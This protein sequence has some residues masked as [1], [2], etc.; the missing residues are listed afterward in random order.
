MS[1][2]SLLQDHLPLFLKILLRDPSE[3]GELSQHLPDMLSV[4]F[5]VA[6]AQGL[7]H[8]AFLVGGYVQR[9]PLSHL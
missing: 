6:E 8:K 5:D 7:L 1:F 4:A 9:V 2:F 3:V